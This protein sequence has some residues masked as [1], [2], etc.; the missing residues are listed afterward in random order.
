MKEN[1]ESKDKPNREVKEPDGKV[2]PIPE[3]VAPPPPEVAAGAPQ[4][5]IIV[6]HSLDSL[7]WVLDRGFVT[8][9]R[10]EFFFYVLFMFCSSGDHSS[11]PFFRQPIDLVLPQALVKLKPRPISYFPVGGSTKQVF[12]W[13]WTNMFGRNMLYYL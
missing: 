8:F 9:Q 3:K 11:C 7:V 1:K 2:S 5:M 10:L 12:S 13:T 4:T 6:L